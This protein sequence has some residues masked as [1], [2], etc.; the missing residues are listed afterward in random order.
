MSSAVEVPIDL[1][2]VA[3]GRRKP[4][5]RNNP[6]VC[7]HCGTEFKPRRRSARFC[8]TACRVAAHRKPD[9]N[10]NSAADSPSEAPPAS[11]NCSKVLSGNFELKTA[12]SQKRLSVT[13]GFAIVP[14]AKWP[15]M[16]RLRLP[17][18]NLSDMVNLP[19]AKDALAAI[20]DDGAA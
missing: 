12:S 19:R 5:P 11:Q 15:A 1:I 3:E 18:S 10:A 2:V 8:G 16:F 20:R 4:D 17:D 6:V 7:S 14:D 9:C 13:R